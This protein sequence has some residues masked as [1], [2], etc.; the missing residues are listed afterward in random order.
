MLSFPDE[1][2]L[3][4]IDKVVM[5]EGAARISSRWH[6]ENGDGLA[7]SRIEDGSFTIERPYA[8]LFTAFAGNTGQSAENGTFVSDRKEHPYR[9]VEVADS[10][11]TDSSFRITVGVPL[12]PAEQDPD[13]SI[14]DGGDGW[15]VDI[16]KGPDHLQIRIID[17]GGLPEFEVRMP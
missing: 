12:R 16:R 7:S 9:F 6:L 8:R 11:Q 3:V 17:D 5:K 14:A 15:T 1:P 10:V 4:V 13:V 2:A